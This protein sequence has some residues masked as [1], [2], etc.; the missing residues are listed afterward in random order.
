MNSDRITPRASQ[1]RTR[2]VLVLFVRLS[3]FSLILLACLLFGFYRHERGVELT[4]LTEELEAGT[5]M[6]K[7]VAEAKGRYD[8]IRIISSDGR[9]LPRINYNNGRPRPVKRSQLQFKAHRYYMADTMKLEPGQIYASPLDLNMEQGKIEQPLKPMLRLG[10]PLLDS[11]GRKSCALIINYLAQSL[12]DRLEQFGR[13]HT[14]DLYLLNRQ[15]YGLMGPSPRELWGFM[16][17]KN[18]AYSFNRLYN[19]AW[20][21][22]QKTGRGFLQ[23][24]QGIF[25]FSTVHLPIAPDLESRV[26][27]K[28]GAET[29]GEEP[30]ANWKLV[31]FVSTAKLQ[32]ILAKFWQSALLLFSI[33]GLALTLA[34]W[35]VARI[36]VARSQ[37]QQALAE[38]EEHFRTL[39]HNL[40]GTVYR[41]ALDDAWTMQFITSGIED[42]SGYPA[43]DF[44]RNQVRSYGDIIL[45]EDRRLVDEAV[46]LAGDAR[47]PLEIEYRINTADGGIRWVYEKGAAFF[48]A[49]AEKPSCPVRGQGRGRC[50]RRRAA[51]KPLDPG[52][53]PIRPVTPGRVAGPRRPGGQGG[54][55]RTANLCALPRNLRTYP[56]NSPAI[57]RP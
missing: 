21:E 19:P 48:K 13:G 32:A 3:L 46:R 42:L 29:V 43:D 56:G 15:G 45:A 39:E 9:E 12:F 36:V 1:S 28:A 41:R 5:D 35:V 20:R 34:G 44:L 14:G 51:G 49:G 47:K 50:G 40:P 11:R 4:L 7:E 57:V 10:T 24:A 27:G 53:G 23:I 17:P 8:Q 16:L 38:S 18:K 22:I 6:H 54:L 30:R 2:Q 26:G 31:Q 25:V 33:L 52:G 55:G 37:S